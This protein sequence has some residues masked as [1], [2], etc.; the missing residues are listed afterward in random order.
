MGFNKIKII[1]F[2]VSDESCSLET[3]HLQVIIYIQLVEK[4]FSTL[5]ILLMLENNCEIEFSAII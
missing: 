4:I 5:I 2:Y 1:N 3:I